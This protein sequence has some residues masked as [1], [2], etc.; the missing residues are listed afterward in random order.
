MLENKRLSIEDAQ[1]AA[2][3]ADNHRPTA[4]A[5]R[6]FVTSLLFVTLDKGGGSV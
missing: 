1:L 6:Q 3:V 2:I 4:V 5:A